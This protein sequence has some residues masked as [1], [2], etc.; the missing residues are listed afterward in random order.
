MTT[1]PTADSP[2]TL[3]TGAVWDQSYRDNLAKQ[4]EYWMDRGAVV[5]PVIPV[6]L[7]DSAYLQKNPKT[8]QHIVD[9]KTGEPKSR[10][11]G[12]APSYWVSRV[13]QVDVWRQS[14]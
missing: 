12:K 8:G 1:T 2:Q 13:N 14:G 4:A 10:F 6:K 3:E 5:L 11:P 9:S 7:L